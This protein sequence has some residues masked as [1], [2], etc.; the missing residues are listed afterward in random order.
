MNVKAS[1]KNIEL[2]YQIDPIVPTVVLSDVTRIRQVLVNLVGNA[3][4]FTNVGR[5]HLH[6]SAQQKGEDDNYELLFFIR[7]SGIGIPE[8]RISKL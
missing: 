3:L 7:D 8:S 6:L 1:E 4:K 2:T 5:V